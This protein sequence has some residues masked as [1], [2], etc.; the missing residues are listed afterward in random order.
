MVSL[1]AKMADVCALG[2]YQVDFLHKKWITLLK[3]GL[4]FVS[5]GVPVMQV[6]I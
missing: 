2:F 5:R 1:S 6:E 3:I 4:L